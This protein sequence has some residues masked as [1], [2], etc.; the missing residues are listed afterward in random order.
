MLRTPEADVHVH[1]FSTECVEVSR[2]LTF[3]DHLR[4]NAE[5]GN[6]YQS[7]KRRLA[8]EDWPD[9]DAYARAKTEVVEQITA[10]ALQ[11]VA[12]GA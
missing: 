4:R 1:I 7:T 6:L 3:R 2:Q 12:N 9:M 10:R 8:K 11:E 5:D